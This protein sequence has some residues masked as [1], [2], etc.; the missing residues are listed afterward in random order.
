MIVQALYQYQ[1]RQEALGKGQK[2]G[3]AYEELK[4]LIEISDNGDFRQLIDLREGKKGRKYLL[5][6]AE[7]R[8][9][10]KAYEKP[11]L[12]WD[13]A[14][15]VLGQSKDQS[16]METAQK[17]QQFFT[18]RICSIVSKLCTLEACQSVKAVLAFYEK[19]G[20]YEVQKSPN[21]KE[22]QLIPGCKMSFRLAGQTEPVAALPEILEIAASCSNNVAPLGRCLI[23][24]EVAPITVLHPQTPIRGG[25]ATGKLIGFQKSSGYDSYYKEQG[26]NAPVSESAAFAYGSALNNMLASKQN[27]FYLAGDSY[28]FWALPPEGTGLNDQS[29][30]YDPILDMFATVVSGVKN[31]DDPND[32]AERVKA[33]FSHLTQGTDFSAEN[34]RFYLL[35]LSPNAGRVSVRLWKMGT[36]LE[37]ATN[38]KKHLADFAVMNSKDEELH[39]SLYQILRATTLDGNVDN[40]PPNLSGALL[41]SVV[42]GA[43]YPMTLYQRVIG[44]IRAERRVK[45]EWAG[46]LKGSLNRWLLRDSKNGEKEGFKMSLDIANKNSAYV[47]GRLFAVLEKIQEAA[48][49][50]I[51]ATIGDRY[52]GAASSTP[53]VVFPHLLRMKKFHLGKLSIGTQIYY[54][55]LVENICSLLEQNFPL[56]L[57]LIEQGAFSLGYYH[58][59]QALFRKNE[60]AEVVAG[61]DKTDD[62]LNV[63]HQ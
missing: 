40:L 35:G 54:E 48:L 36:I 20:I 2:F 44:R 58:Q 53:A 29:F 30:D 43:C 10:K 60:K 37:F 39:F 12:L 50:G 5:P 21:W 28:V 59:R 51:N 6:Q 23:T 45:D 3:S 57:S 1:K 11:C 4:F 52:Y 56:R 17:K 63:G 18:K 8:S 42:N 26:L 9:G 16:D 15:F 24:G 62:T 27:F 14:D 32:G 7:I 33:Y 13:T 25:Q 55:T 38:L 61:N 31:A 34:G 22:C 19:G 46:V 41:D 49:P 47:M